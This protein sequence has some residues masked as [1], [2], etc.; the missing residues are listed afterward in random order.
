[1]FFHPWVSGPGLRYAARSSLRFRGQSVNGVGA[2][3]VGVRGREHSQITLAELRKNTT[4]RLPSR[5]A[6][7]VFLKDRK[8]LPRWRTS[9]RETAN[10]EEG[11]SPARPLKT[12]RPPCDRKQNGGGPSCRKWSLGRC[13]GKRL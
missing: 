13:F 12:H 4:P 2:E 8:S 9:G 10:P 11:N 5:Q 1:M 7:V 6:E 3:E